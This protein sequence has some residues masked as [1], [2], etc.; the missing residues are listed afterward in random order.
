[1]EAIRLRNAADWADAPGLA[2]PLA[3]AGALRQAPPFLRRKPFSQL[4]LKLESDRAILGISADENS[5]FCSPNHL[6]AVAERV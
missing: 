6:E 5:F 2:R 3:L 4:V 1:M